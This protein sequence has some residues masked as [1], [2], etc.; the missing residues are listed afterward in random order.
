M[1]ID[2]VLDFLFPRFCVLCDKRLSVQEKHICLPCYLHLPRTNYHTVEHS[3]ME[4][5]FWGKDDKIHIQHAVAFFRYKESNKE[6]LMQL[7]YRQNPDI[8]TYMASQFAKEILSDGS[9]FFEGIDVIVP[10]PIH[11]MRRL[12]RSYNQSDYIAQGVSEVTGIPV[13]TNA[14]KRVVNNTS[15]TRMQHD[16]RLKNTEGIFR[17]VRPELLQGK[18]ILVVDDVTT[19]GATISSCAEEIAKAGNI[20]L[21]VLTIAIAGQTTSETGDAEMLPYVTISPESISKL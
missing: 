7:K 14:V 4:R 6:I 19:T 16:E 2:D 11:W 10:I 21:S 9:T 17:L 13:C 15:Q 1:L 8:G 12:K 5:F 3:V 18:H 20:K